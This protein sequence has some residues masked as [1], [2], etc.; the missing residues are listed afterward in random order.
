L[1]ASASRPTFSQKALCT[2]NR[3]AAERVGGMRIPTPSHLRRTSLPTFSSLNA[4]LLGTQSR[5]QSTTSDSVPKD[6]PAKE[7]S[8]SST[9]NGANA[10]TK[11]AK[12]EKPAEQKAN[13]NAKNGDKGKEKT[14]VEKLKEEKDDLMVSILVFILSEEL[15]A[16][17]DF[18]DMPWRDDL[19]IF[20]RDMYFH[21]FPTD[22]FSSN[23]IVET[24]VPSSRPHECST[25]CPG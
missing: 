13:G 9:T 4:S 18:S 6:E 12:D 7:S 17:T 1:S 10:E 22:V 11:P 15:S 5:W 2:P 20:P 24:T 23:T 8:A 19:P 21:V 16:D 14:D 25:D 3:Y